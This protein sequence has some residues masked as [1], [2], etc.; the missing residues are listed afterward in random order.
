MSTSFVHTAFDLT[1]FKVSGSQLIQC[2]APATGEA[3]GRVNP[4]TPSGIDRAIAKAKFAQ[5]QWAQTS[6]AERRK[7][8][9][10]MLQFVLGNQEMIARVACRDSGKTMVDASLGEI[11]V[12]AEK[13]KWT[14]AHGEKALRPER[15]PTNFLMMYKW[16]EVV[17]QPL[18][19]VAACVSWKYVEW[20]DELFG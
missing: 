8:L 16:N 4:S 19:V 12:T 17:W 13:L 15:R 18:G 11:L 3:L 5:K 10:T 14:I 6:F 7:V 2:Y 1:S 20:S 9:K